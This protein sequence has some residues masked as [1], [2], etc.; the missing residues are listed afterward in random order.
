MRRGPNLRALRGADEEDGAATILLADD[1][2]RVRRRV[3]RGLVRQGY[4][5]VEAWEGAD[6]V[7]L[8]ARERAV[9]A[10]VALP[11]A[12]RDAA[13][14]AAFKADHRTC[15]LPVV[16]V[17]HRSDEATIRRAFHA[18][19]DDYVTMPFAVGELV[20]VLDTL[21]AD[22]LARHRAVAARRVVVA[23]G[24][25]APVRGEAIVPAIG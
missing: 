20:R 10:V 11:T 7:L 23:A 12:D 4:R 19:A 16:V 13:L 21:L 1:D 6:A 17:S 9:G 2:S 18:G 5:V 24:E 8:A 15:A 22:E 14:C 25:A 3:R